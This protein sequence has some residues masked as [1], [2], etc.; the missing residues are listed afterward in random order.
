[1]KF[2]PSN[3]QCYRITWTQYSVSIFH[4][5]THSHKYTESTVLAPDL[6]LNRVWCLF[7]AFGWSIF[8]GKTIS[9]AI[10]LRLYSKAAPFCVRMSS[11]SYDKHV[12]EYFTLLLCQK[13]IELFLLLFF[14]SWISSLEL[15]METKSVL[16]AIAD[17]LLPEVVASCSNC[18]KTVNFFGE[19]PWQQNGISISSSHWAYSFLMRPWNFFLFVWKL[20]HNVFM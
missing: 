2:C 3:K 17:Y 8:S 20:W 15:W 7:L 18:W 19:W 16:F 1:M 11:H 14:A 9:G 12:M 13:I 5:N 10:E 4:S 6:N